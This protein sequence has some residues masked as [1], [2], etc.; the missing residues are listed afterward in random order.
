M[1]P[2][3]GS[4]TTEVPNEFVRAGDV[5]EVSTPVQVAPPS[6]ERK[7]PE[8]KLENSWT[9]ASRTEL[10]P[11]CTAMLPMKAPPKNVENGPVNGALAMFV[12][13]AP[14]SVDFRMPAP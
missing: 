13:V 14:P 10:F 9:E 4:K 8:P 6:V 3:V 7:I 12:Q 1:L 11:G 2:L 5:C